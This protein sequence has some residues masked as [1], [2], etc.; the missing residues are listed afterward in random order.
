MAVVLDN[1]HA[2]EPREVVAQRSGHDVVTP[3][4]AGE[5]VAGLGGFLGSGFQ[6]W[7]EG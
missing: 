5:G 2:R 4:H 7:R 3:G 1:V 6:S